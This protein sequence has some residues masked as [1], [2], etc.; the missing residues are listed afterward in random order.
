MDQDPYPDGT[1][2]KRAC[3]TDGFDVAGAHAIPT[4]AFDRVQRLLRVGM[5][6]SLRSRPKRGPFPVS[7]RPAR[8]PDPRQHRPQPQSPPLQ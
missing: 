4:E 6:P 7:P 3:A 1:L 8:K 2:S 5:S